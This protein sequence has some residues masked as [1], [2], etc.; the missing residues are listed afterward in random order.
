LTGDLYPS[1]RVLSVA[2]TQG[3]PIV[4]VRHDTR[5]STDLLD[6]V[7]GRVRFAQERKIECFSAT[8]AE[9]FDFVRLARALGLD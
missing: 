9:R 3:V 1:P 2:A 8:L 6:K 5:A 4:L 7:F